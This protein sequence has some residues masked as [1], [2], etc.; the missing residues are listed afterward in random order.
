M[1]QFVLA[2]VSSSTQQLMCGGM[3]SSEVADEVSFST[4]AQRW[5]LFLV[6]TAC[7]CSIS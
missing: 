1:P 3:V 6:L 4:V 2:G 7:S 5:L